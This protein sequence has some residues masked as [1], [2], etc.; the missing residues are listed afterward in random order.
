MEFILQEEGE[1]RARSFL[2]CTETV[3]AGRYRLLARLPVPGRDVEARVELDSTTASERRTSYHRADARGFIE[4]LPYSDLA[5][6]TLRVR[7]FGDILDELQGQ[8]WQESLQ[9]FV[10]PDGDDRPPDVELQFTRSEEVLQAGV[11]TTDLARD[12]SF[13]VDLPLPEKGNHRRE[14]VELPDLAAMNRP[15]QRSLP[16]PSLPPK[17]SASPSRQTSP[18]LPV[19]PDRSLSY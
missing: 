6:G 4:I 5:P 8:G 13:V 15:L 17:L 7:C 1:E 11:A 14:R 16:G 3:R 2:P 19:I 18:R 10:S 9:L 12:P